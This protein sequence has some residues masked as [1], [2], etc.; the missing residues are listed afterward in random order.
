MT[1]CT[2][3]KPGT[4][5]GEKSGTLRQKKCSDIFAQVKAQAA[6][7]GA[8]HGR[9]KIRAAEA[10]HQPRSNSVCLHHCHAKTSTTSAIELLQ[11][12]KKA[13]APHPL[14]SLPTF[15]YVTRRPCRAPPFTFTAPG[16]T[17]SR[18][19]SVL[20]APC[21]PHPYTPTYGCDDVFFCFFSLAED[22][23]TANGETLVAVVFAAATVGGG[24]GGEVVSSGII[25]C[26]TG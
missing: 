26:R 15:P 9:R 10:K 12:S 11:P 21:P 8:S 19:A 14:H 7:T 23:P 3:H 20:S 17:P 4:N 1:L 6:S 5:I 16:T 22:R 24:G 18:W 25:K 2:A 13:T